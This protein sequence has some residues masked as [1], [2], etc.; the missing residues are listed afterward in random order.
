MAKKWSAAPI[1]MVSSAS[2]LGQLP[3]RG[4]VGDR[5]GGDDV[6]GD[7]LA[8]P[9]A[10]ARC[11]RPGLL[12]QAPRRRGP[13][14]ALPRPGP[15]RRRGSRPPSS[16]ST[17]RPRPARPRAGTGSASPRRG[18][19]PRSGFRRG[20]RGFRRR[21]DC[22]PGRPPAA[23]SPR[24]RAARVAMLGDQKHRAA[25]F[26]ADREALDQSEQDQGERSDDSRLGVGR[27]HADQGGGDPHQ[28][29]AEHQQ[30]LAADPVAEM[31]EH[32]A[33]HRPRHEAERV[34]GE[35]EQ[36]AGQRI[37]FGEEE[38]V[39]DERRGRAVE[40][41]IVP[42]DGRADQAGE[43]HL[44][45][46]AGLPISCRARR[47][48]SSVLPARSLAASPGSAPELEAAAGRA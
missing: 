29:E 40:E 9:E 27:E 36:G 45:Q 12:A 34:G 20:W 37:E 11:E 10:G 4:H 35:G 5:E 19:R 39:E 3:G 24:S 1:R 15:P 16:G 46:I 2:R 21:A 31:A 41:E 32:D 25:P 18:N 47:H 22:R 14:A 28:D 38:L 8:E 23:S 7:V 30:P 42:F 26:A 13:W 48:A 6:I 43:H 33:S 17:S 44:P